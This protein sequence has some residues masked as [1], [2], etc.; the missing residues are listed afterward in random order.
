MGGLFGGA[1]ANALGIA[2][3]LLITN[4]LSPKRLGQRYRRNA[5]QQYSAETTFI[6]LRDKGRI[7]RHRAVKY[8]RSEQ[9]E[10]RLPRNLMRHAEK[11]VFRHGE[12]VSSTNYRKQ[13]QSRIQS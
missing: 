4:K 10:L 5:A 11:G 9:K 13:S 7:D 1:S 2:D 6:Q 3:D 8:K 12:R